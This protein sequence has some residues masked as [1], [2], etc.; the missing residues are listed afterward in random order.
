MLVSYHNMHVAYP[1]LAVAVEACSVVMKYHSCGFPL[2]RKEKKRKTGLI[3]TRR[4]LL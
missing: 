1:I 3:T 2:L 4:V